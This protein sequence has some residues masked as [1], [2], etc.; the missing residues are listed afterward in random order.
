MYR[1]PIIRLDK[2]QKIS[3]EEQFRSGFINYLLS[4]TLPPNSNIPSPK[5]LAADYE[6]DVDYILN[7]FEE[8][9][10]EGK[11]EK[12]NQKFF[13]SNNF[14]LTLKNQD[15]YFSMKKTTDAL[16]LDFYYE[17]KGIKEVKTFNVIRPFY[18]QLKGP[19]INVERQYYINNQANSWMSL[20]IQKSLLDEDINEILKKM[21]PTQ[22][23]RSLTLNKNGIKYKR[24]VTIIQPNEVMQKNL[25]ILKNIP[26]ISNSTYFLNEFN[27]VIIYYIFYS[28]S[29]SFYVF[30]PVDM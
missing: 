1:N 16:G 12:Q 20:Y 24:C 8:L 22:L 7:L 30:E 4:S 18:D 29:E 19:Y 27:E 15:Q 3:I 17:Y 9:I 10:N 6:I 28:S 25:G 5:T 23:V 14:N 11:L 21:E 13:K 2:R 26:V